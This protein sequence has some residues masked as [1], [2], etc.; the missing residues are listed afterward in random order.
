[1]KNSFIRLRWAY[2]LARWIFGGVFVFAGILKM[3][4]P[5][6]FADNIAAYQI[7][8]VNLINALALGLPF[9]EIICGLLVLGGSHIRIGTLGIS[10]MLLVFIGAIVTALKRGLHIDCGCF[11]GHSWIDSNLWM[12]LGHN[13]AL[14]LLAGFI[15]SHCQLKQTQ[16]KAAN[17]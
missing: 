6:E 8:P 3:R 17:A 11:G 15:Y 7:L 9:F 13:V 1:M 5:I 16:E 14:L 10:S 4:S 2:L 12:A